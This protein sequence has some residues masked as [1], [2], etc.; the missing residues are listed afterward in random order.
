MCAVLVVA[1]VVSAQV[2]PL[3]GQ[4]KYVFFMIG[5]GMANVQI[6]AAEAY[7]ASIDVNDIDDPYLSK[8]TDLAMNAEMPYVGMQKTWAWNQLITD[9]AAAGTALACGR[10]TYA[11]AIS[12]DPEDPNVAYKTLGELAKEQ[13]RKVGII[14]S[15]SLDHAT[16]A[17]FYAH[18]DTRNKYFHIAQEAANSGT[19]DFI[20]GG[21]FRYV[22]GYTG[23]RAE[24]W[25][26]LAAG[27]PNV[28][29]LWTQFENN[30]FTVV[31]NRADLAAVPAGAKC[32]ATSDILTD[33]AALHYEIDR[34]QEAWSLAEITAEG[35][36]LLDGDN[37]F[38]MMVEGGKIDWTCHANDAL[39][40][41]HD[42]LAFDA[43][44]QVVIDFAKQHPGE[45]L[46]VIT[47]DH[48]TGGLTQGWAGTMYDSA[49]QSLT[50]QT[51]SYEGF[52]GCL[53]AYQNDPMSLWNLMSVV[54][55]VFGPADADLTSLNLADDVEMQTMIQN[56][57]GLVYADLTELQQS[58]LEE[59]YDRQM[60]GELIRGSE[61]D[62]LIYGGYSPLG[63]ACTH[64][65]NARAG[66][67]WTSYSHTAVPVPVMS[68]D[69]RFL[70]YYDNTEI[71]KRIA[72]AMGGSLD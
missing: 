15:V 63:V 20:G 67:A 49:Y 72:E 39:T 9:S 40:S 27:D 69:A 32:V 64:L 50:T 56:A 31:H 30:G 51:M 58:Q 54:L 7:L 41:I 68:N 44:C 14:S 19:V 10:K 60:T 52:G 34:P 70:G 5:D 71:G 55:D 43:A 6:H 1:S 48:E 36:R 11:G 3:E 8:S 45:C 59:A 62:Y 38:F 23:S 24:A 37:G 16:P 46:I 53:E 25:P 26:E 42:T 57:F 17:V 2:A 35:I 13:G 21:G 18:Q 47:A 33:G 61:E 66:L 29:N 28:V 12:V 4:P 22:D 65:V